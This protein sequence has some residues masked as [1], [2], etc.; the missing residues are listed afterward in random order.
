MIHLLPSNEVRRIGGANA[1][2]TSAPAAPPADN[3]QNAAVDLRPPGA[4]NHVDIPVHPAHGPDP[5]PSTRA[6]HQL[7]L[8]TGADRTAAAD[9]VHRE[10]PPPIAGGLTRCPPWPGL[11]KR[12]ESWHQQGLPVKGMLESPPADTNTPAR[13]STRRSNSHAAAAPPPSVSSAV[14]IDVA[15]SAS[16]P[17]LPRM[18]VRSSPCRRRPRIGNPKGDG[19]TS[20]ASRGAASGAGR[21]IRWMRGNCGAW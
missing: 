1:E 13:A 21:P 7:P 5:T 6:S 18:M 19:S 17:I 20:G 4:G 8:P 2:N 15:A 3:Q 11:A 12:L 9:P 10:L 14:I 16:M